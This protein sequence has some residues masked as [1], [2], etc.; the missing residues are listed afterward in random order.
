MAEFMMLA[1][2]SHP[3]ASAAI[4]ATRR[5]VRIRVSTIVCV[6][7]TVSM[8]TRHAVLP[9]GTPFPRE[10]GRSQGLKTPQVRFQEMSHNAA[11]NGGS[12]CARIIMKENLTT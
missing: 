1:A 2:R 10:V 9:Q 7:S 4:T 11:R 12:A 3:C 8:H 5:L 6:V